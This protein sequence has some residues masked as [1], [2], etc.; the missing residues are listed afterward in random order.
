MSEAD[1]GISHLMQAEKEAS[2]EIAQARSGEQHPEHF[3]R[4]RFHFGSL[5]LQSVARR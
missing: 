5:S 2:E 3:V 4:L 1:G